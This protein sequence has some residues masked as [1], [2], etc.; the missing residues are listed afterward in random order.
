[1]AT[2]FL[3]EL[4]PDHMSVRE[5]PLCNTLGGGGGPC[6]LPLNTHHLGC[7]SMLDDYDTAIQ[8]KI[9]CTHIHRHN[10]KP[11]RK[12]VFQRA[13]TSV[14]SVAHWQDFD[15]AQ[16]ARKR[17]I[18]E[19]PNPWNPGLVWLQDEP[20]DNGFWGRALAFSANIPMIS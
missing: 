12:G 17:I 6:L 8:N 1:M 16:N 4:F 15:T 9:I 20:E 5:S 3:C 13:S 18:N 7:L 19:D 2:C 11:Q 14:S 10:A